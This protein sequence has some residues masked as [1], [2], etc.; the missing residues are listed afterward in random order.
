MQPKRHGSAL[1]STLVVLNALLLPQQ[2]S[3]PDHIVGIERFINGQGGHWAGS[4]AAWFASFI[5]FPC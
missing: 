2:Y 1:A 5:G 4:M 3:L